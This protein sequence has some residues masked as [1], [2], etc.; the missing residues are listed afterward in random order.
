MFYF[1]KIRTLF[2]LHLF[3]TPLFLNTQDN[4]V[5]EVVN[6]NNTF[7]NNP[8]IGGAAPVFNTNISPQVDVHTTSTIDAIGV[9]V[10]DILII[11]KQTITTTIN[12]TFIKENYDY[13]KQTIANIL[14]KNRYKIAGGALATSYSAMSLFLIVDYHQLNNSM[15]WA[16]WKHKSTF[17]DLCAI[18]QKELARELMLAIGEHHYN[19]DNP[20]DL[21]YPLI[22][23]IKDIDWEIA[24]IKRYITTTKALKQLYLMSIF[25]TND[26][27]LNRAIKML[28][29]ALFIRH[30]FLSWLADYNLTSTEKLN[31]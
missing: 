25:P 16:Q 10:G 5:R 4:G 6:H 17:E 22:A 21:A 27:K 29:R 28:E 11:V 24:T 26:K 1:S 7:N 8:T 3:L 23:F 15:F 12:H 9:K 14:W 31:A 2:L 20:T 30:I 19:K 18:P 13:I